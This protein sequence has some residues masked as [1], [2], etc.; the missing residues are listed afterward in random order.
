M[1]CVALCIAA[2]ALLSCSFKYS[3]SEGEKTP[4]M[5]FTGAA[6]QRYSGGKMTFEIEADTMEVYSSEKI[7]AAEGVRFAEFGDDGAEENAASA[8]IMLLDEQNEVYTLGGDVAFFVGED[9][10]AIRGEDLRWEKPIRF[11]SAPA[12]SS[13]SITGKS[14]SATGT[15]FSA[16]TQNRSYTF[17]GKISGRLIPEDEGEERE[18]TAD[19]GGE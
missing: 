1:K 3:D 15:G 18:A 2:I 6:A 16:N 10:L 4:D 17:A 9:D 11:I 19:G 14:I 12:E 5:V 8:G 13:V 7:W